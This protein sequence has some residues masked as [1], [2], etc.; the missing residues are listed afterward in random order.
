MQVI[1]RRPSF[2]SSVTFTELEGKLVGRGDFTPRQV[3]AAL[4]PL[5]SLVSEVPFDQQCRPRAAFYIESSKTCMSAIM[6][7]VFLSP[8][9]TATAMN[10]LALVALLLFAPLVLSAYG[11]C[12]DSGLCRITPAKGT[13]TAY[14]PTAS[15]VLGT[16]TRV[17]L[18]INLISLPKSARLKLGT[19]NAEAKASGPLVLAVFDSGRVRVSWDGV[20]FEPREGFLTVTVAP[21]ATLTGHDPFNSY[22]TTMQT[23][24][25]S[26]TAVQ[27]AGSVTHGI[28][29]NR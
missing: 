9:V 24:I 20:P 11:N 15:D 7:A 19:G 5:L 21:D 3:Q 22:S 23:Y 29:V 1:A 2:V 26:V 25:Q 13:A 27:R 14:S 16:S 4:D 12:A 6:G 8:A 28:L 10:R 17:P 18:E